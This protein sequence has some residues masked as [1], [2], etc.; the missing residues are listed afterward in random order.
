MFSRW[1]VRVHDR[2]VHKNAVKWQE[3]ERDKRYKA[4]QKPLKAPR[5]DA[6]RR[7]GGFLRR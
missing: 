6:Q 2:W 5:G 7:S 3:S 1:L 4:P